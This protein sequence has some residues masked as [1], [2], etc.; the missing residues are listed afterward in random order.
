MNCHSINLQVVEILEFPPMFY[1]AIRVS[2]YRVEIVRIF[3]ENLRT[4]AVDF[5]GFFLR[6]FES[7]AHKKSWDKRSTDAVRREIFLSRSSAFIDF[8]VFLGVAAFAAIIKRLMTE[9]KRQFSEAHN[10]ESTKKTFEELFWFLAS[11]A[12]NELL[13]LPYGVINFYY[14]SL[15]HLIDD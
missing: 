6:D 2:F 15:H 13:L 11:W 12:I 9:R 1:D 10:N 4:V 3:Q 8:P 5:S 7:E 14:T